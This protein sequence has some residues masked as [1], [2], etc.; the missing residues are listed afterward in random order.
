MSLS[1]TAQGLP[2]LI[3]KIKHVNRTIAKAR[4]QPAHFV[5]GHILTNAVSVT[6]SRFPYPGKPSYP[7]RWRSAAQRQAVMAK[8]R[9]E[10]NLPYRRT[11]RLKKSWDAEKDVQS[12][13]IY[14]DA[15]DPTTGEFYAD[16]VIGEDQQPFH[17]DTG[18][19]QASDR[20][21]EVVID[22]IANG[23]VGAIIQEM[24]IDI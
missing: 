13:T 16:Y 7:L 18:H 3:R 2:A 4:R 19:V 11:N 10:N 23:M 24:A 14:N 22:D 12:I 15:K 6:K 21:W 8:L 9:A 5:D 1:V 20:H 17:A